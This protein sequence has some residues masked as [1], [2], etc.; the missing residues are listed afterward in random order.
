M[1]PAYSPVLFPCALPLSEVVAFAG[2]RHGSPWHPGPVVA[3]VLGAGGVVRV[4]CARGVDHSVRS[5]AGGAPS[6]SLVVLSASSFGSGRR[7][8][9]ELLERSRNRDVYGQEAIDLAATLIGDE[10]RQRL[11]CAYKLVLFFVK[12]ALEAGLRPGDEGENTYHAFSTDKALGVYC[13]VLADLD[14]SYNEKTIR[15]WLCLKASHAAALAS[16]KDRRNFGR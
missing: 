1:A 5:A 12:G 2:S 8:L 10:W 3:A 4:G 13:A 7:A 9:A 11:G 15:R 6:S 14:K 16:T